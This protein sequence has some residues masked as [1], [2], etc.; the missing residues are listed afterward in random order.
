[1]GQRAIA[2]V[3]SRSAEPAGSRGAS[4]SHYAPGEVSGARFVG[5]ADI[6]WGP[7]EPPSPV[8]PFCSSTTHA[9]N[10]CKARPVHGTDL[11]IGHTNQKAAKS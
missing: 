7:E 4:P 8:V 3:Y 10:A 6:G 11:C 9:G 5:E 1:M 2:L